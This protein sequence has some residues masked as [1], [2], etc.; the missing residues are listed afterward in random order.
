MKKCGIS[1]DL[2]FVLMNV[3]KKSYYQKTYLYTFYMNMLLSRHHQLRNR[4]KIL[5]F[6]IPI[7]IL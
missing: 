4:H 7:L 1:V 2:Q 6:F 3:Q 5:Q